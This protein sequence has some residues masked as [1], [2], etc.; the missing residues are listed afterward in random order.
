M[1]SR[2]F[3]T[4]P[5]F[6]HKKINPTMSNSKSKLKVCNYV[7]QDEIWKDHVRTEHT[8][9]KRWKPRH[10]YTTI[11]YD[12]LEENLTSSN[13]KLNEAEELLKKLRFSKSISVSRTKSFPKQMKFQGAVMNDAD[14]I[15]NNPETKKRFQ[16]N[17]RLVLPPISQS[18]PPSFAVDRKLLNKV[19][20][21][22]EMLKE[23]EGKV[24]KF[25]SRSSD[26][27]GWL[28]KN[29]QTYG[30]FDQRARGKYTL[31]KKLDWP[32]ESTM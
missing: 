15:E 32:I 14:R 2:F 11:I 18:L 7:H 28:S 8:A 6:P 13:R 27:I 25:P 20:S 3:I 16:S 21:K 29:F 5:N 9:E 22:S 10:G 23:L 17:R 26:E 19:S 4:H 12:N 1:G 24:R 31:Y 30:N